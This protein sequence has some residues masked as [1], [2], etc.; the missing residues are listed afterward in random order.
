MVC[1]LR[2]F[3]P[4]WFTGNISALGHLDRS[5]SYLRVDQILMSFNLVSVSV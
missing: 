5:L 2:L 1:R 4:R 3:G